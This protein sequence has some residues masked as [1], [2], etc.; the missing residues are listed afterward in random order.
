MCLS[1]SCVVCILLGDLL[2]VLAVPD[3]LHINVGNGV[4]VLIYDICRTVFVYLD[5]TDY[6]IE[7]FFIGNKVN[8]TYDLGV[9]LAVFPYRSG[10]YYAQ[11][12]VGSS[13]HRLCDRCFAFHSG[14]VV[15]T[16]CIFNSV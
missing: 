1:K 12:A 13:D 9:E 5:R 11:L 10:N 8:A 2:Y 16:V 3:K 4:T 15:F 14:F 7:E 6:I